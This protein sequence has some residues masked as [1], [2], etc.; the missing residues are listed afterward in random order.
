MHLSQTGNKSCMQ[1]VGYSGNLFN[2]VLGRFLLLCLLLLV[3]VFSSGCSVA[4][5]ELRQGLFDHLPQSP[6]NTLSGSGSFPST[7][8]QS[9]SCAALLADLKRLDAENYTL[10]AARSKVQQAAMQSGLVAASL[11]PTPVH[12]GAKYENERETEDNEQVTHT[13]TY[14]LSAQFGWEADIWGRLRAKKKAA[15]LLVQEQKAL[16]R[17]TLLDLQTR[18]VSHWI[19]HQTAV[20]L[21]KLVQS[22][23]EKNTQLLELTRFKAGLGLGT[24]LDVLQQ[25]RHLAQ[26]KQSA[27]TIHIDLQTSANA[28]KVLLGLPPSGKT[29][30][31]E[32][33]PCPAPLSSLPG[34]KQLLCLRPDLS[35]AFAALGAADHEVA[36]AIADRLP[37]IAFGFSFEVSGSSPAAIGND[38]ALSLLA[39][40]LT[41]VFDAGRKA[42]MVK[43]RKAQAQTALALLHQTMLAALLE[44]E[45]GVARERHLFSR[46]ALLNREL[47]IAGQACDEAMFRYLNGE[48]AFL[49]VLSADIS[50]DR[51]AQDTMYCQ[52]A[53][54][55]NRARLLKAMGVTAGAGCPDNGPETGTMDTGSKAFAK[56]QNRSGKL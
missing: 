43:Q 29:L 13:D 40:F 28:Y 17:Q 51:L 21:E 46:L 49:T 23:Q 32:D 12:V 22:Q 5:V 16:S 14:T 54:L 25:S 30:P 45:N 56:R 15:T 20:K 47:S 38:S 27:T 42:M 48:E 53:L 39:K 1:P 41:P 44:V 8:G 52:R 24:R 36:A 6:G 19:R 26:L 2:I 50:R 7:W 10:A 35:A 11:G 34:P 4:R 31:P 18:L 55:L 3:P 9:F 33:L 37:R